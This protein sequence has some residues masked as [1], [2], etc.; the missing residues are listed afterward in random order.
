[1]TLTRGNPG[2]SLS[3]KLNEILSDDRCHQEN[4]SMSFTASV[5]KVENDG[6]VLVFYTPFLQGKMFCL[7]Q[8]I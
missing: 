6:V 4:I 8:P 3:C 1:M 7:A 5:I 2:G